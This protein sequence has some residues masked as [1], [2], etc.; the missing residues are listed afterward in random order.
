MTPIH[1][2]DDLKKYYQDEDRVD[3]YVDTRFQNA[4][5]RVIHRNQVATINQVIQSRGIQQ[6][7][8]LAPGPG[9]ATR[10]IQGLKEGIALDASPQMLAEASQWVDGNIWDL[11][12]GDIFDLDLGRKFPL[13]FSLRFI[14]HLKEEQRKIVFSRVRDHLKENGLFLFDAPN[15]VVELPIRK[16]KPHLF[17]VYDKLWSEKELISELEDAGFAVESLVGIMKH[18]G[19]QRIISKL[20]EKMFLSAGTALVSAL[21]TIPSR[22]P[23]EWMVVCRG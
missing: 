13:I 2:R 22:N 12:E 4:R 15:I 18:H 23:L 3:S 11:Q 20:T 10:D 9:R 19:V 17:P 7:L 8:E 1:E 21:D 16:A 14:R 5:G 6:A